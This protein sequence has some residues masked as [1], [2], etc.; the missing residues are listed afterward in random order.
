MATTIRTDRA[1]ILVDG[2]DGRQVADEP[3]P[4]EHLPPSS[5]VV[6]LDHLSVGSIANGG[7]LTVFGRVTSQGEG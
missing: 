3:N 7:A 6:T 5:V 1:G 2:Q 4:E